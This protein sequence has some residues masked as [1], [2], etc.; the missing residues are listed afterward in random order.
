MDTNYALYRLPY[1]D[2]YTRVSSLREP[3]ILASYSDIGHEAG[4]VAAPFAA[5][6]RR[7]P[8]VL[9][10]ADRVESMPVEGIP[11]PS[12]PLPEAVGI[13]GSY[14]E[15]FTKFHDAALRGDF[16]K[17]VLS[18]SVDIPFHTDDL[19]SVFFDACLRYP[20]LMIMLF[21]TEATGT[22][23][24]ASPEILLSGDGSRWHTMALAGTMPY[25]AG[26]Q[27]WSMKNQTE[28]H[29]VETF[30]EECIARYSNDIIKDGPYTQ[31]A[32]NLVHFCTDFRFRLNSGVTIGRLISDLHPTPA[33]CGIPKDEARAFILTNEHNHRLYYTGFMGPVGIERNTHLYV[34]LRCARLD[35]ASATLYSGGGIM[36]DSVL[37]SEWDETERKMHTIHHVLR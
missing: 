24:V 18:R 23:L 8:I 6:D 2:F 13:D 37:R 26:L 25:E 27:E 32:G 22:W 28:Q 17:I 19:T 30:I 21:S 9:L 35:E 12:V 14:R 31:R 4:F 36:P 7:A 10:H 11:R 34:A 16:Q 5:D 3:L 33:T 15:D 29:F 20:R 1:S